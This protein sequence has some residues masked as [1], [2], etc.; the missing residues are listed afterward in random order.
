MKM[1]LTI[2]IGNTNITFGC[3][4]RTKNTFTARM[5][6]DRA[7]TADQYG[8]EMLQILSLY[9]ANLNDISDAAISSVVPELTEVIERAAKKI[10][11]KTPLVVGPG[12][13]C[14]LNIKIDNPAQL[15]ADLVCSAVGAA[16][17]Y[18]LP[19]LV[20]DLG[21]ATKISVID[22]DGS[23]LG[24]S[25][26][27][28]VVIS[29]NA[30]SNGTSLLPSLYFDKPQTAIGTNTVKSMQAGIVLG[31]AAMLDGMC[32]KIEKELKKTAA[33][34]VATGGVAERIIPY[35]ERDIILDP[36]LIFDGLMSIYNKN[37]TNKR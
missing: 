7:K 2:D 35:C 6:T 20:L 27:P 13:K 36:D 23:F 14:G 31:N 4:D 33:T 9:R 3:H 10:T 32:E 24:C 11:K 15:G 21:T 30:L 22:D 5:S 26:S 29:M 25:I 34:I 1:I 8:A 18:P 16:E 28:G 17:K 12:V 37:R 19:C